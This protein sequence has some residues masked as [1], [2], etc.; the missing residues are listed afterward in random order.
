MI[1]KF[2]N[3]GTGIISMPNGVAL[4]PGESTS[5]YVSPD[6][7][8]LVN[9]GLPIPPDKNSMIEADMI[10]AVT[11]LIMAEEAFVEIVNTDQYTTPLPPVDLAANTPKEVIMPMT[12]WIPLVVFTVGTQATADATLKITKGMD[13]LAE[14]AISKDLPKGGTIVT[15]ITVPMSETIEAGKVFVLELV[16]AGMA[17]TIAGTANLGIMAEV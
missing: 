1:F 16:E 14:I 12:G 7:L 10:L 9:Q 3:T 11:S 17:P 6:I 13:V 5:M 15:R 4:G 2:T 8:Y